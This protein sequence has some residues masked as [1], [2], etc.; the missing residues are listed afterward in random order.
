IVI[1]ERPPTSLMAVMQARAASPSTCTVQ[2][3]HSATPQP[4]FVPVIP[5]SSRRYQSS[6]IDGSPS[7]DCS[8]PLTRN[9]TIGLLLPFRASCGP[10]RR[11]GPHPLLLHRK[12][13]DDPAL[14]HIVA[15]P[16]VLLRQRVLDALGVDPPAR[17][18]G[19]V[20][21]A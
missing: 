10:Q 7:N 11:C 5:N 16:D 21:G 6:G 4:N 14:G 20:L 15:E 12:D 3:P 17:L 13:P 18:D 1:T 2:A 8:S 9:L 19:D